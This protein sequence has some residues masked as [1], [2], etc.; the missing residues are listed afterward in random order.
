MADVPGDVVGQTDSDDAASSDVTVVRATAETYSGPLPQPQA[1]NAYEDALPGAADRILTM[2][3]Q[4]A[5]QQRRME[6]GTLDLA[7]LEIHS[8]YQQSFLGLVLGAV[9]AVVIVAGGA[10]MASLGHAEAGAGVIGG[11]IVG[12]AATFVYGARMRGPRDH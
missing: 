7:E 8:A 12:M 11:T 5:E 2:A 4:K 10:Y 3:E 6:Q 9:V 1:M